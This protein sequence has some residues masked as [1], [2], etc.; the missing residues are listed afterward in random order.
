M[1]AAEFIRKLI[2]KLQSPT[3]QNGETTPDTDPNT[4]QVTKVPNL[5]MMVPV[6]FDQDDHS[7]DSEPM[8]P[9]PH[10]GSEVYGTDANEPHSNGDNELNVIKIRAGLMKAPQ[11]E[12]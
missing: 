4:P 3:N 6:K 9:T 1:D 10:H 5:A 2:N 7:D 11:V 12:D 8:F